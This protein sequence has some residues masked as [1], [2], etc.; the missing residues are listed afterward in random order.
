MAEPAAPRGRSGAA[1][2]VLATLAVLYTLYAARVFLLPL[3][4]AIL[5]SLVLAPAV[6]LLRRGRVPEPLG[7]LL[8]LGLVGAA[9]GFGVTQ[10]VGPAEE[11]LA[12]APDTM[13]AIERKLRPL[14]EPV[15]QMS[16]ASEEIGRLGDLAGG[17]DED[18]V[19]AVTA[20]PGPSLLQRTWALLGNV[21]V[22]VVLVYF[23]L[24]SGD[25]PLRQLI[26]VLPTLSDKKTALEIATR[27]RADVSAYLASITLVNTVF[28]AAVGGA[29]WALGLPNPI[30]WGVVAGLTNFV[31]YLGA[32]LCG[33][34]LAVVA[35][36]TFDDLGRA[37]LVP[38]VFFLLNLVE[39]YLVTP[40]VIA[41]RLTLSPLAIF[42]TLAFLGWIWGVPGTLLAVPCLAVLKILCDSI[43]RMKPI[44]EFLSE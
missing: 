19:V 26:R 18:E 44:G 35:L 24:A 13:R 21:V 23:L 9:L 4:V 39:S 27:I 14:Q 32:L 22:T 10:I 29:M 1:A 20:L 37:V 5:L 16:R 8:V 11:W 33:A 17:D 34:I 38:A 3:A 41:R 12:R 40:H 30:L 43:P 36:L 2:V 7:A 28:G 31:P 42:V 6:R 25:R 15:E